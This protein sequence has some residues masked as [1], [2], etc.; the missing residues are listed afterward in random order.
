VY[1]LNM[2]AHTEQNLPEETSV[3]PGFSD[4]PFAGLTPE[5][6]AAFEAIGVAQP[7]P[8]G[9]A[10]FLQDTPPTGVY[11]VRSG[12]VKLSLSSRAGKHLL[13]EVVGPGELL[14]LSA[15][16]SGRNCE[17]TA[18]CMGPSEVVFFPR[19]AF[20]HFLQEHTDAALQVAQ[21]LSMGLDVAHERVRALRER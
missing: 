12:R 7:R 19:D 16:V 5:T 4:L 9:D 20:L 15:S 18:E 1:L 10:L 3:A 13:L 11:L 6:R 14:G 2:A 8:P 17:V 21:W